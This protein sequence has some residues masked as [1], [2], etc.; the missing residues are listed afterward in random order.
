MERSESKYGP[1]DLALRDKLA[2]IVGHYIILCR[3]GDIPEV[4]K[5]RFAPFFSEII[6]AIKDDELGLI[7]ATPENRTLRQGED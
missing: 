1:G 3:L 5:K 4:V 6:D 7:D 2:P